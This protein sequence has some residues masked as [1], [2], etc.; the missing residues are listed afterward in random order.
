MSPYIRRKISGK[1][2][3]I[4]GAGNISHVAEPLLFEAKAGP[5]PL[6][7]FQGPNSKYL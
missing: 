2:N 4:S 6:E 7:S 5:D 3:V 1:N